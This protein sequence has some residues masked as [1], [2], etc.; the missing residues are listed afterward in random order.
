[1]IKQDALKAVEGGGELKLINMVTNIPAD[2]IPGDPL[3]IIE[4]KINGEKLSKEEM[5][6]IEVRFDDQKIMMSNLQEAGTIPVNTE[7]K[8]FL[9]GNKFKAGDELTIEIDVPM[10][11]VHMEFTRTVQ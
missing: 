5:E 7:V 9:P 2:Q 11:S 4:I 8:F 10:V 6:K 1:M 3:D